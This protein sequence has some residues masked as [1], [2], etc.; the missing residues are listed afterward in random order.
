MRIFL[1]IDGVMMPAKGWKRPELLH[2]GFPVFSVLATHILQNM[3]SE[4]TI[5]TLTTSHKANFSVEEWKN[6][7]KNRNINIQNLECLPANVENL[8]RQD[9]IVN[10]FNVNTINDS[11][12]IIDDDKSLN[13]LPYFLKKNLVQTSPYLGLTE[14]HLAIA[15]TILNNQSTS[16]IA[17]NT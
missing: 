6:I 2:D 12:I 17:D 1:D 4:D 7:F 9:E 5:I 15:K 3:I 16:L 8:S 10:W 13:E 14:E 11:F